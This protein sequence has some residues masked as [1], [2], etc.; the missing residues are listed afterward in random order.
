LLLLF[1][2]PPLSPPPLLLLPPLNPKP[3]KLCLAQWVA[4]FSSTLDLCLSVSSAFLINSR[5]LLVSQLLISHQLSTFAC[6]WVAH[7]SATLRLWLSFS[8]HFSSTLDLSCQSVLISHQLSTFA[9]RSVLISHQLSTFALRRMKKKERKTNECSRLLLSATA[10]IHSRC[11]LHHMTHKKD[12][13]SE[14]EECVAPSI[15]TRSLDVLLPAALAL[16]A[17]GFY[18]ST[19][20][21]DPMK[22]LPRSTRCR[23]ASVWLGFPYSSRQTLHI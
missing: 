9:Y 15:C 7:F 18:V 20:G 16:Y 11:R 12:W 14:E 1:L 19:G 5:R 6:Q 21:N 8:P 2:L 10:V 22:A 3:S 23:C 17:R 13:Q 4:H